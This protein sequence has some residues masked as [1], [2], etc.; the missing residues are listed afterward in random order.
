[1]RYRATMVL[2]VHIGLESTADSP[3]VVI[4]RTALIPA[5]EAW[6]GD[7]GGFS[8]GDSGNGRLS[9]AKHLGQDANHPL[10]GGYW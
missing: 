8:V 7:G 5:R 4:D 6:I 10:C 9:R 2:F 1:L 3:G